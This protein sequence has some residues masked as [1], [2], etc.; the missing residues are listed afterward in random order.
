MLL[1]IL[2]VNKSTQIAETG[3]VTAV[4]LILPGELYVT[5]VIHPSSLTIPQYPAVIPPITEV[6]RPHL[7][8]MPHPLHLVA[9]LQIHM[10]PA[11]CSYLDIYISQKKSGFE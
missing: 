11:H 10:V 7:K 4:S 2:V 8:D 3:P 5:S 9:K 6:I 1:K